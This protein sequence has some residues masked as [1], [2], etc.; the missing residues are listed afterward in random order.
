[1]QEYCTIKYRTRFSAT[2]PLDF[3]SQPYVKDFSKA[4]EIRLK[5]EQIP[6]PAYVGK[7]VDESRPLWIKY[8][9]FPINSAGS[10]NDRIAGG[11]SQNK[12][13]E[14]PALGEFC[15]SCAVADPRVQNQVST[16]ISFLNDCNDEVCVTDL[17]IFATWSDLK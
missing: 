9:N 4:L 2:F 1:M 15:K 17:S 5:F 16:A 11:T 6:R 13:A 12:A 3:R 8:T 7:Q 10:G 14:G